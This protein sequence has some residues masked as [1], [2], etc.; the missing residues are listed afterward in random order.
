[1]YDTNQNCAIID[2]DDYERVSKYHWLKDP[3]S[4]YWRCT[5]ITKEYGRVL[6]HRFIMNCPKGKVVDHKFLNRDDNRKSELRVCTTTDNNRN[7]SIPV[8]KSGYRGITVTK[9]GKFAVRIWVNN[10]AK[11]LGTFDRLEEAVKIRREAEK[12]YFGEYKVSREV[13]KEGKVLD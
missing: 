13:L 5:S 12:K 4:G 11:N 8:G 2:L 6:L 1:M 3:K 10:K 9:S 7:T